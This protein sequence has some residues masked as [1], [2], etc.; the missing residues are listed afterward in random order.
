MGYKRSC[1]KSIHKQEGRG[2]KKKKGRL[3]WTFSSPTLLTASVSANTTG[4]PHLVEGGKK[5]KKR[6][7]FSKLHGPQTAIWAV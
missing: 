1:H 3:G 7:V 6:T 4:I 5:K 2:I